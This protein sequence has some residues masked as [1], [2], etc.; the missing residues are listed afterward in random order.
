MQ[1]SS[2]QS[3]W[4]TGHFAFRN[5]AFAGLS[6]QEAACQQREQQHSNQRDAA[7]CVEQGNSVL[8]SGRSVGFRLRLVKRY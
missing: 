2:R 6:E 3:A 7:H 4:L 1:A 8:Q 5:L